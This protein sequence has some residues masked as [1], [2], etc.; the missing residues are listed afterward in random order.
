MS[1]MPRNPENPR[2][3]TSFRLPV[4]LV[5]ALDQVADARMLGRSKLVELLLIDAL[6]RL[7]EIDGPQPPGVVCGNCGFRVDDHCDRHTIPCCPGTCD[8]SPTAGFR[9]VE[10][11]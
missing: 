9:E 7:P 3:G 11:P 1:P 6:A 4:E 10:Q 5:D 2:V 8:I